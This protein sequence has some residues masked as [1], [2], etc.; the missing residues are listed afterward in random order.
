MKFAPAG[1][2]TRI[3]DIASSCTIASESLGVKSWT[4]YTPC[5]A[6]IPFTII[7]KSHPMLYAMCSLAES[8][9]QRTW[10]DGKPSNHFYQQR[11]SVNDVQIN[12]QQKSSGR[13]KLI[14]S[15]IA[16][17]TGCMLVPEL[18]RQYPQL[19]HCHYC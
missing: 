4:V 7:Y 12:F 1:L 15:S 10:S 16:S 19:L 3:A 17:A 9:W 6:S 14:D 13:Y 18:G 11:T 5:E 2:S 8:H